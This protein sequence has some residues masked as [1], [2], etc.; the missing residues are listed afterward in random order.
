MPLL[1]RLIPAR[2]VDDVPR[3]VLHPLHRGVLAGGVVPGAEV[4][5]GLEG[6]CGRGHGAL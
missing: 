1:T 2:L 4:D 3:V 6:L 5:V